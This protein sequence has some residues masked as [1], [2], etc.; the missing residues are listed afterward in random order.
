MDWNEAAITRLRELW[1]ERHSTAE[2]ARRMGISKNAVVGKAHRLGLVSRPS[3]IKR[4]GAPRAPQIRRAP[5][6]TL[7][8]M[9][10]AA[11]PAA[12]PT[13]APTPLLSQISRTCEWPTWGDRERVPRPPT[14]CGAPVM[15]RRDAFGQALPC[16]Y[17]PTHFG[18]SVTRVGAQQEAEQAQA[19]ERAA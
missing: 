15:L 18:R 3:P 6:K 16:P 12:A 10:P 9:E 7:A 2:I 8:P 4:D 19:Q 17:C 13:A 1:A 5:A 14:F 11:A